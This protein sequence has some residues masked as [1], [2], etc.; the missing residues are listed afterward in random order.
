[1]LAPLLR[2]GPDAGCL[3]AR[4]LSLGVCL[5]GASLELLR[6]LGGHRD[7]VPGARAALPAAAELRLHG[8]AALLAGPRGGIALLHGALP[9]DHPCG[10]R[11]EGRRRAARLHVALGA[12]EGPT[13]AGKP[14]PLERLLKVAAS[15]HLGQRLAGLDELLTRVRLGLLPKVPQLLGDLLHRIVAVVLPPLRPAALAAAHLAGRHGRDT[16]RLEAEGVL[17]VALEA[18][19]VNDP[20]ARDLLPKHILLVAGLTDAHQHR[21]Q[22][23]RHKAADAVHVA[24]SG[25]VP[26]MQQGRPQMHSHEA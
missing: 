14:V 19:P 17:G 11:A 6:V 1:M 24:K 25:G 5:L 23:V 16:Y 18:S 3:G 21:R 4:R 15:A 22:H 7:Q 2:L 10:V 12:R 9:A 8:E 26:L 20:V 13:A